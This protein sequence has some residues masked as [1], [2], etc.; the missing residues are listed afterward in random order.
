M[1]DLSRS[2]GM[3]FHQQS[4]RASVPFH[5]SSHYNRQMEYK[6]VTAYTALQPILVNGEN[7]NTGPYP[8]LNFQPEGTQSPYIYV[9]IAQ[10]SKVGATV[11]WREP[12][13]YMWVESDYSINES[14]VEFYKNKMDQVEAGQMPEIEKG[15]SPELDDIGYGGI[16]EGIGMHD[17]GGILWN[18]VSD[19]ESAALTPGGTYKGFMDITSPEVKPPRVSWAILIDDNGNPVTFSTTKI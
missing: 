4:M 15:P 5:Y 7:I 9:P 2:Y 13:N 12:G 3:P 18:L 1:Y 8:I 17:V 16:I 10:F 6:P 11:E 14:L 19:D